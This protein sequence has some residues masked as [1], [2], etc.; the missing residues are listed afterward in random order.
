MPIPRK[1]PKSHANTQKSPEKSAKD[2]IFLHTIWGAIYVG[3]IYGPFCRGLLGS[4]PKIKSA[5]NTYEI[6]E[7]ILPYQ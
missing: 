5:M 3:D 1:P 4:F 2:H 6:I 7:C